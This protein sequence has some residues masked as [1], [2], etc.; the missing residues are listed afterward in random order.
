M[1]LNIRERCQK[2][3][4]VCSTKGH[5]TIR[6]LAQAT[7]IS[8]SS[9]HRHQQAMQ[10]RQQPASGLWE[11]PVGAQWLKRLV[12]ATIFVF[13]FKRG[14]GCESLVEFFRLL[15]LERHVG[16]SVSSLRQIRTQME[17]QILDYQRLQQSQLEHP[18]TP[19][20]ACISVDETFFD[21]VVL[22][23]LDLPSGFILVEEL[24]QD[25]RYETWQQ[26]TQQVL[27]KLGLNVHYCVSDRA[28]ALVKLAV[29]EIGCP[30]IA[31]LFHALRDLSQGLGSELSER[32][33]RVNRRLRELPDTAANAP[34][35]QQLQV[36]QSGLEQAQQQYR[37]SLHQLTTTLHP[38]AIRLG[39][40]QTSKMVATAFQQQA[41]T[42]R[43]LKQTDQLTDKP[44]SLSKFERQH[45]DL[46]AVVDL[47]W[48][49]VRHSLRVRDCDPPTWAWV[50]QQ[51]L[52]AFYWHQQ[53]VRTKTPT[54]K[55]AY[56]SAT[57][58]AQTAFMRHPLTAT[59]S[60]EQLTQWQAWAAWMVTKFQRTSSPVEGR[61]GYLSQI[62]HNRRGLSSRRL[63]VM[64]TIHNFH[65][66][67][68]D[69][70]TAAE[71]LFG[72]SSTD[73]FEWLIQ[74]MTD[75][76]QARRGKAAAKAKTPFL[77][78]VPA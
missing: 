32:L 41:T 7:G 22:V 49:W 66:K 4:Q 28:K 26:H 51:L 43:A 72:K 13:C 2:V 68:A 57:Q 60:P 71:R 14:V 50:E 27:S 17:T 25:Y 15:G 46:A 54:L 48:E 73:L 62:H 64:T 23:M 6:A 11:S 47:W 78:S 76:P 3:F 53:S 35:R 75:L 55:A 70:S 19:V 63:R 45:H 12:V 67:R 9:V 1:R 77:P 29:H 58:Q 38:F 52:P 33:F 36:Q 10:R 65:L 5:R 40:P 69:G 24:S 44:G 18:Q 59:L 8:K 39:L 16:L 21:Q 56:Q 74:Q 20:E 42:L 34:L 31:D 61:N 30:S 37:A